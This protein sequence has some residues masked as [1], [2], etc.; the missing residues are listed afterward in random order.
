MLAHVITWSLRNR[1][2][3]L[4]LTA[5]LVGFGVRA[6]MKMPIDAFPDTTPVMVQVNA[7]AP[8]YAPQEIEQQVTIPI[9]QVIAG[10]PGLVEV[11]SISK[12]GFSQVVAVFDDDTDIWLARQV[13]GERLDE[14]DLPGG[15]ERPSLGPVATGLGEVY[16]YKVVGEERSLEELT[17]LHDWEIRPRLLSV[18]GVAE[19]NTWGGERREYQVVL[20]PDALVAYDLTIDRVEDAL[21]RNNLTVGG[22]IVSSAGEAHLVQGEALTLTPEEIGAIVVA[23]HEGTPVRIRDLGQARVGHAIRR[24]AVTA[25]GQGETVLGLAFMLMGEN[26]QEVTAAIHDRVQTIQRTLPDG[27]RIVP[28]YRRTEL[29]NQVIDTVQENLLE[30]AILVIAVLFA[31]LG[32]LRAGLIVA[33][34]IPF[35]ML[36][37]AQG[38]LQYGIAASLLSL[39]AIDFGLIVDS[40]VIMVENAA[41]RLAGPWRGRTRLEVI[42]DAALEVRGPTMF[43][44]LIILVVFLPILTLE[45]VEGKLFRPMALTM[46]F[47]LF[48]SMVLSLTLMPVLASFLL[49][50]REARGAGWLV[51]GVQAIYR[52]LLDIALKL[53]WLVIAAAL[54]VL[55]GGGWMAARLGSEFLPK[56]SEGAITINTVRL[57]GVSLEESVR[58]GDRLE[59]TILDLYPDE[60]EHVWTR[61]GTAAVATDPMG[62]EVSDVFITLHPRAHWRRADSQAELVDLMQIELGQLP[63]MRMIYSQPIEMR[64]NEMTAGIRS[65][66]GVKIFG[67][68]LDELAER[69]QQ[70]Q[71]ILETVP[72]AGDVSV[73]QLTGQSILAIE[74]DQDAIA[75]HGV[76]ARHVL[77]F[78]EAIGGTPVGEVRIEER[79]FPLAIRLPDRFREDTRALDD[80][81]VT[82]ETGERIPLGEL[83]AIREIEGPATVTREW[84][85]RRVVVSVN[86]RDRDLG[87]FV[88]EIE[89]RLANELPLEENEY[90]SFGGQYEHL[91]RSQ[92]RLLIVIPLALGLILLLLFASTRSLRDSLIIF[93]GAPLAT[94]GGVLALHLRDMPFTISAAVGFVAVSGVAML[95]GLVLTATIRRLRD[96]GRPPHDAIREACL[97]RLRPILMTALV[98][99]LGFVP[100]ALNTGVGAEVQRPLATV[101]IGG[102]ISDNV[103]TL[104]VLPALYAVCTRARRNGR[105]RGSA[106]QVVVR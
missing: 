60:V 33:S 23:A 44:E 76:P 12:F 31:F 102:V 16:H 20:D 88:A 97:R 72:G 28:L 41:S 49:P 104:L 73:E 15:V 42:R 98:A 57:A 8:A 1:W 5:V 24:G 32:S 81:L 90:F 3:V 71:Q 65:D 25:D 2:L 103:L 84:Q 78:V 105:K 35:S 74:V 47:A 63:G 17:T 51:R 40:S 58:Y 4:L 21:R 96:R 19:V 92:R 87:G 69:A 68:D 91:E 9:E 27:V 53:R 59:R 85:K 75:R 79:R 67:P 80:V 64:I 18:P 29:V 93:T 38:M 66:L 13:V 37:A 83:A 48:G 7:T 26:P 34:A 94:V 46:V 95:N 36:F 54:A 55:C 6:V 50:N 52:P 10:L 77:E 106:A 56:L 45:G 14:A 82:T 89:E 11:R 39:G 101:V 43:G 99:A 100:M 61:T 62:L 22:G 70:A 86:V 30:G